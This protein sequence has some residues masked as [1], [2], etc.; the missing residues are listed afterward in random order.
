M[1]A[2][3]ARHMSSQGFDTWVVEVRGAGLS[4]QNEP[5]QKTTAPVPAPTTTTINTKSNGAVSLVA[6]AWDELAYVTELTAAFTRVAETLT[7]YVNKT[8]LR[9]L[10]ESFFDQV[11]R[12]LE[13]TQLTKR[14]SEI[15]ERISGLVE[16]GQGSAITEQ[17]V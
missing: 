17:V 2:S 15:E 13:D 11:A 10:Y 7:G 5:R 3:F 8:Q 14:L 9:G 16:A 12:L 6:P 4:V 1:Q